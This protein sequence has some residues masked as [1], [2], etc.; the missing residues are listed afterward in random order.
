MCVYMCSYVHKETVE[1][2]HKFGR[3]REGLILI[4]PESAEDNKTL[5]VFFSTHHI[6][7]KALILSWELLE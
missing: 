3:K 1:T 6:T 5:K 2:Q 4:I 7:N